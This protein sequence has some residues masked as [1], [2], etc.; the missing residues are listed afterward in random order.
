MLSILKY[1]RNAAGT[2]TRWCTF[3]RRFLA[4]YDPRLRE[5]RG[6]YYTPKPVVS[7]IVRSIDQLFEDTFQ[8]AGWSGGRV[9]DYDTQPDKSSKNKKVEVHKVLV[10]DPATGTAT[11]PYTV[12][13]SDPAGVHDARGTPGCGG[14]RCA[15]RCCRAC[16]PRGADGAL[17]GG[18][19]SSWRCNWRRSICRRQCGATWTYTFAP[20]A[21]ALNVFLDQ[22][23]GAAA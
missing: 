1:L 4:A 16:M 7:F 19:I 23:A 13:D 2:M 10:L 22:H 21:N 20:A 12:I 6:V 5:L 8:P 18:G 14:L 17:R 3:T 15:R 11:F 9:Q